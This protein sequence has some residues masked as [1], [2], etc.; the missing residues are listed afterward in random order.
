MLAV[1]QDFLVEFHGYSFAC[2]SQIGYYISDIA[3]F[4]IFTIV[5]I[6]LYF[7]ALNLAL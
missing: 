6:N 4:R 2:Q 7:H 5:A 1:R 3:V